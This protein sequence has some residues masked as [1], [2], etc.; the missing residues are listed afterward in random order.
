[1]FFCGAGSSVY[2]K[3]IHPVRVIALIKKVRFAGIK[4][5]A[6]VVNWKVV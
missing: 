3:R 5:Q 6:V 4:M 1:M 2:K